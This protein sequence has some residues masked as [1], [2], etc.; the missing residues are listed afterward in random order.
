MVSFRILYLW[1]NTNP[2]LTTF[3]FFIKNGNS[4]YNNT[5][6]WACDIYKIKY[7]TYFC[8]ALCQSRGLYINK[9]ESYMTFNYPKWDLLWHKKIIIIHLSRAVSCLLKLGYPNYNVTITFINVTAYTI[10]VPGYP[11]IISSLVITYTPTW[12]VHTGVKT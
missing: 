5:S 9:A 2:H 4:A 11:G 8:Y 12:K 7:K 3:Y 10:S 1:I 6:S